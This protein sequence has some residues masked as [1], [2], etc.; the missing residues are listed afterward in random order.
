M[1]VYPVAVSYL[2]LVP[3]LKEGMLG[4]DESVGSSGKGRPGELA[5]LAELNDDPDAI[6]LGAA[7]L[8]DSMLEG[9]RDGRRGMSNSDSLWN[10]SVLG[11]A[12]LAYSSKSV[13]DEVLR[14]EELLL[15]PI[16]IR[17]SAGER[18]SCP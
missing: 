13:M 3:D 14:R 11:E 4:I 5:E 15:G 16:A 12:A 2:S 18:N 10:V 1:E 7:R 17:A 6:V 9:P 8:L